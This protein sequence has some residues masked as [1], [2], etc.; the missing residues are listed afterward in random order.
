MLNHSGPINSRELLH[1]FVFVE[2]CFATK[3]VTNFR[4]ASVCVEK[5]VYPFVFGWNDL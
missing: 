4:E 3:Y 5:K 1:F 2:I